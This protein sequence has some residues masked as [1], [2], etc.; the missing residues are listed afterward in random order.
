MVGWLVGDRNFA[1]TFCLSSILCCCCCGKIVQT[2][3]CLSLTLFFP[4]YSFIIV[5]K[6]VGLE[7]YHL[8]LYTIEK[9]W[10]VW[11]V[12]ILQNRIFCNLLQFKECFLV[13][14]HDF[15]PI[16]LKIYLSLIW[17]SWFRFSLIIFTSTFSY[18]PFFRSL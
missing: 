15:F 3:N 17:T 13:I 9:N 8:C 1:I 10:V 5:L 18:F 2:K 12:R 16:F 4:I 6:V 7:T 14:S 11:W